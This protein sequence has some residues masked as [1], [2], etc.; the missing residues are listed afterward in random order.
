MHSWVA[1]TATMLRYG[2][3]TDHHC[4]CV[5]RPTLLLFV[6]C[7]KMNSEVLLSW[8][9]YIVIW[10]LSN[11]RP[12]LDRK[13]HCTNQNITIYN[14]ST[15]SCSFVHGW[16]LRN[17]IWYEVYDEFRRICFENVFSVISSKTVIISSTFQNDEYQNIRSNNFTVCFICVWYLVY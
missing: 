2:L 8:N 14:R 1:L 17:C 15:E 10:D 5:Y 12:V 16:V 7:S 4:C 6:R 3:D 11:V 13:C 9:R